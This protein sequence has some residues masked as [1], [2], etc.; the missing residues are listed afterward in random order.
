MDLRAR[1]LA[2]LAASGIGFVGTSTGCGGRVEGAEN[3]SPGGGG[4]ATPAT[5]TAT[6]TTTSAPPVAAPATS[7]PAICSNGQ[8]T[9][10][11][12]LLPEALYYMM[13]VPRPASD[14]CPS[15][16]QLQKSCCPE[17]VSGPRP[18]GELCCYDVCNSRGGR[19]FVVDG[20]ERVATIAERSGWNAELAFGGPTADPRI[21]VA[22]AKEALAEHASIASF[23]RF[24]LEL[25]AVGAPSE[26]VALA[27][28]AT[29]DEVEHAKGCFAIASRL[30]GRTYGPGNLD[31]SGADGR[32]VGL[33]GPRDLA[34]IVAATMREGCVGETISAVLAETRLGGAVDPD[35]RA[36][37]ARI[38]V[39]EARHAELA[40][41]FVGWAIEQGGAPVQRAAIRAFEES[42]S[43]PP[44][45]E[46][47]LLRHVPR[48]VLVAYGLLDEATARAVIDRTLMS[49]VAPCVHALSQTPAAA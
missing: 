37:L 2:A 24:I 30:G 21:A 42:M 38:A 44:S 6:T 4:T 48:E 22:W 26:L 40:W 16:D 33:R 18:M 7:A 28:D 47:P 10:Q 45:S 25:L 13:G 27:V 29:R 5:P 36:L 15:V 43:V 9:T 39:D 20:E 46:S 49:V 8:A 17:F 3:T 32:G 35:T 34:A 1:F 11:T 23:G 41:R 31:I 14:E 19:P 12:C